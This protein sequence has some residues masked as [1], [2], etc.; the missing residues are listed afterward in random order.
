[1]AD[2]KAE[3]FRKTHKLGC[4]KVPSNLTS[5][6]TLRATPKFVA[7]ATIDLRDYCTK[8]EDQGNLPQCAAYSAAGYAENIL[9]RKNDYP[10]QI[11]PHEIYSIA[12]K[13]DG[14]PNGDGTTLDAVLNALLEKGYFD[15]SRCKVLCV[16]DRLDL[17]N[18]LKYAIHKF[19]CALG[20]FNITTE[21]FGLDRNKT[22]LSI[23]DGKS[24]QSEGGHAVLICGYNRDGVIIQNSW[25]LDWG[26]FGTGLIPWNKFDQQFIYCGFLSN[27]LDGFSKN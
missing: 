2:F 4:C 6:P 15:R 8:T 24:Y 20:A 10:Q 18:Q 12:K 5:F 11:D 16:F 9:W 17:R 27:A 14:D 21:W 19:G 22:S 25:G 1:M 13:N 3:E 23:D 7:P 26:A